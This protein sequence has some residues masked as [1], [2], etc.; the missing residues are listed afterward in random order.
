LDG[1]KEGEAEE[2]WAATT[3][4]D[5][6]RAA[7]LSGEGNPPYRRIERYVFIW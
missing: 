2:I 5:S 6:T 7:K 1:D 4:S 3:N